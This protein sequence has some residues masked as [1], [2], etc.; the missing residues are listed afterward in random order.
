M[1]LLNPNLAQPNLARLSKL[2]MFSRF[3]QLLESVIR[4]LFAALVKNNLSI[5][6]RD[7]PSEPVRNKIIPKLV[8]LIQ[9]CQRAIHQCVSN[10]LL[11][12]VDQFP[13]PQQN[14]FCGKLKFGDFFWQVP[15]QNETLRSS[16]SF[17]LPKPRFPK[18]M[19]TRF[20]QKKNSPPAPKKDLRSWWDQFWFGSDTNEQKWPKV[21]SNREQFS[22]THLR[23]QARCFVSNSI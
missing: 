7:D 10:C 16:N 23:I 1:F 2:S 21:S 20:W 18:M 12:H 19:P 4:W 15:N 14:D 8:K 13:S 5:S 6:L 9:N 3:A 17:F 22:F 11:G